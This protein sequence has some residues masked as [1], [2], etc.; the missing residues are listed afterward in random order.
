MKLLGLVPRI[1]FLAQVHICF[2]Y[3][4]L[5][6]LSTVVTLIKVL[7]F[8]PFSTNLLYWAYWAWIHLSLRNNAQTQSLQLVLRP[9]QYGKASIMFSL[10]FEIR[11]INTILRIDKG[12]I[13]RK[14]SKF[15][16]SSQ[17]NIVQVPSL[18]FLIIYL[19]N[20]FWWSVTLDKT[21]PKEFTS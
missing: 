19:I 1:A 8:Y 11:Y 21:R 2:T 4:F 6:S 18:N 14:H 17:T 9:Y 10:S 15:A 3:S 20:A 5:K 13:F 12:I 7:F 16:Y